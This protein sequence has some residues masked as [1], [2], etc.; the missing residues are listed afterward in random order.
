MNRKYEVIWSRPGETE[1]QRCVAEIEVLARRLSAGFRGQVY[2]Y[3]TIHSLR[4]WGIAQRMIARLRARE[5][6]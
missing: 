5:T 3:V 6:R 2:E 4:R 1:R